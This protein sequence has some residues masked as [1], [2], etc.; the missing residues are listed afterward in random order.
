ILDGKYRYLLEEKNGA[1]ELKL[2]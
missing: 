2:K 1:Y